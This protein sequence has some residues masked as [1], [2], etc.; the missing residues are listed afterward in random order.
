[1]FSLVTTD[2]RVRLRP[3]ATVKLSDSWPGVT[4]LGPSLEGASGLRGS[5]AQK[6]A[7]VGKDLASYRMSSSP[8]G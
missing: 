8:V 3:A 2:Q 7:P 1:M 5:G 6:P 4:V